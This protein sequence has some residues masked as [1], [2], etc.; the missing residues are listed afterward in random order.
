MQLDSICNCNY[1][2]L[3]YEMKIIQREYVSVKWLDNE[4]WLFSSVQ[5]SVQI[6]EFI[7]CLIWFQFS[8]ESGTISM[9]NILRNDK[10]VGMYKVLI[11]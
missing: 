7:K 6:N 2:L 5:T 1:M 3:N 4:Y 10:P 8:F 9:F 11:S